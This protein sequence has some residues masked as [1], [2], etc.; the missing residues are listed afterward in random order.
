M[1]FHW[2]LAISLVFIL[3]TGGATLAQNGI[4]R[5]DQGKVTHSKFKKEIVVF[6]A[7]VYSGIYNENVKQDQYAR[8][9]GSVLPNAGF[10]Y[11]VPAGNNIGYVFGI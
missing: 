7:P 1:R 2:P 8:S 10:N 4:P 3:V 9:A 6:A 11:F 5:P